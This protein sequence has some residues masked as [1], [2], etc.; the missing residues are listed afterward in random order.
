MSDSMIEKSPVA[1]R[2]AA[3]HGDRPGLVQ[4]AGDVG[5]LVRD[6][7][8]HALGIAAHAGLDQPVGLFAP[9]KVHRAVEHHAIEPLLIGIAQKVG[10][11]DGRVLAIE[12]EHD[13]AEFGVDRHAHRIGQRDFRRRAGR[14]AGALAR[15]AAAVSARNTGRAAST[16]RRFMNRT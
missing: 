10:G 1:A 5:R 11:G 14:R 6:R 7:L 16:N 3:R 9:G 2:R 8:E 12:I 15:C 4:D 13:R